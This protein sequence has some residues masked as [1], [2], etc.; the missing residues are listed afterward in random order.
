MDRDRIDLTALDTLS[1]A[2]RFEQLVNAITRM[3]APE[4]ARRRAQVG[5][6]LLLAHWARPLLAAAAVVATLSIGT[7]TL[8]EPVAGTEDV[9]ALP[10]IAEALE[11]PAPAV[12]W[13]NEARAPSASDLLIAIADGG[14]T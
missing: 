5:P 9:V 3:A 6:I 7:L 12:D 13:I 1:D 14:G 2:R 11:V 8:S 4:L 10:G